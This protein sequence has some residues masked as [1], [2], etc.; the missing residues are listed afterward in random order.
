MKKI[1]YKKMKVN[2]NQ[3]YNLKY[4]EIKNKRNLKKITCLF[5]ELKDYKGIK[6]EDNPI[7]HM[8]YLKKFGYS[9]KLFFYS[10]TFGVTN[11]F[12]SY[13]DKE[14][15]CLYV[16]QFFS[17]ISDGCLYLKNNFRRN[18]KHIFS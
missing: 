13:N 16:C 8:E 6:K 14:A 18:V 17:L 5:N 11:L 7:L 15:D 12:F 3:K 10:K 4:S 1:I 2:F 9:T